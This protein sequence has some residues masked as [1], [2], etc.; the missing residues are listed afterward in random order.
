MS[1]NFLVLCGKNFDRF[2]KT[3]R[4]VCVRSNRG[5]VGL[6]FLYFILILEFD[7]IFFSGLSEMHSKFQKNMM[8]KTCFWKKFKLYVVF[9]PS[10][11][12]S[13]GTRRK[14]YCEMSKLVI[15]VR[16]QFLSTFLCFCTG[17]RLWS[18][19]FH[20]V[21][22]S[23]QKMFVLLAINLQQVCQIWVGR[24]Q[25]QFLRKFEDA[26]VVW[27]NFPDFEEKFSAV[28]RRKLSVKVKTALY[29]LERKIWG[30]FLEKK[31]N[32]FKCSERIVL[33][34]VVWKNL[35]SCW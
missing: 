16:G 34:D 13:P 10:V 28:C 31:F 1:N 25:S 20:F 6:T 32:L 15:P 7:K 2:V 22:L 12:T 4:F 18:F 29:V 5:G 19:M 17:N 11:K 30:Q 3:S 21:P 33:S 9:A 35:A 23:E 26:F 27:K 14:N 8:R 24:A